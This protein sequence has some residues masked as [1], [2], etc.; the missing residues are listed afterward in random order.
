M[1]SMKPSLVSGIKPSGELHIGNYL[2]M[3]RNA[4]ALQNS[5]AY[6]C[7]YFVADYHALTQTYTPKEKRK[8]IL[9]LMVDLLAAGLNPERATLFIQSRVPEH[10]NL[11]WIFNTITS[12]GDLQRMTA[13]KEK[14]AEGHVPNAG[15]FDYPVL[16]AADILLY[17][18][19][20]VPVGDDQR[21]HVELTRT[22]ARNFNKRFGKTFREPKTIFTKTSRVMSLNNPRKKMSKSLPKGCIFLHDT[23]D[24]IQKKIKAAVTDSEKT[25]GFDAR[26]RPA[27]ANLLLIYAEFKGTEPKT[28]AEQYQNASYAEFKQELAK[29]IIDELQQFRETREKLLKDKGKV[30]KIFEDGSRKASETARKTMKEVREKIGLL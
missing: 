24:A 30:L 27:I 3:L 8:E 19:D 14:I 18:P 7:F 17:K 28:V 2:G 12:M 5:G 22:I 21:Q 1:K 9:D 26:N 15:L 23:P 16:M 10:A 13:Y 11:A 4:V 20:F 6:N 25:I 29:L